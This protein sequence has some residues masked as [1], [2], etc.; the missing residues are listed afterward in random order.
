MAPHYRILLVSPIL[1]PE[2]GWG[3]YAS[4]TAK[5]LMKRGHA[6]TALVPKKT[7]HP[8]T[9]VAGLPPPLSLTNSP[10][11]RAAA[12][13]K[14]IQAVHVHRPDIIHVLV[15]PYA[16][17]I[18]LARL[19]TKLPPWVMNLH[20]TYTVLPLEIPR[21]RRILCDA[22]S[23]VSLLLSCSDYTRKRTLEG[24]AKHCSGRAAERVERRVRPFRFGIEQGTFV[25]HTNNTE[26]RIL[27]VGHVK[28]R[29]GIM[30]LIRA[31]GA[32]H[33]LSGSAFRLDVVGEL[34]K[35]DPYIAA[36]KN[37]IREEGLGAHVHL[38]GHL[39]SAA[40]E[41]CFASADLFMMLSISEGAQYEG[42][43]LVFLE[44]A[45]RGIP[46]IGST[47]SGCAEALEEGVSG[48]A[49]ASDDSAGI[50][51]RMQ[52]ILE[53]N[54]IRREDCRKW[55]EQHSMARQIDRFEEFY[56]E[57]LSMRRD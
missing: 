3:T 22:Y 36:V 23:K 51:G 42:F 40:L 57:A 53:K 34:D 4:L 41:E 7:E 30:E 21:T 45:S 48:Y 52:D 13:W 19:F 33:R 50:A 14:I 24:I 44:A 5:E 32:F 35:G 17:A 27:F 28:H 26:K 37:A 43:G 29:K 2:S 47:G 18:P 31:C 54:F 16:L 56:A 12:A 20:G 1:R 25:P 6:V 11:A 49:L 38:R 10:F 46:V 39:D 8:C 55:A 9:Q 15:E